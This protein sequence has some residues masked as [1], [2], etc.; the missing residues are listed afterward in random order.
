M[1]DDVLLPATGT[2]TAD[3]TVATDQDI[4]GAHYQYIKLAD[5]TADSFVPIA[6]ETEPGGLAVR[7]LVEDERVRRLLEE[8]LV[9]TVGAQPAAASRSVAV[10][11]GHIN[12]TNTATLIANARSD[13][14][15]VVIVNYQSVS[16]YVGDINVS[17]TSGFLLASGASLTLDTAAAIYGITSS[18]YTASGED[19]KVHYLQTF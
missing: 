13:K 4:A 9:A 1:A 17:T 5:P 14:A 6:V 15:R 3:V 7:L 11:T 10:A 8:F 16:I 2:G 12:V 19:T 18:T